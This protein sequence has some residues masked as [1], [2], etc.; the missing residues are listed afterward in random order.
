MSISQRTSDIDLQ[1]KS[2]YW[3]SICN[4]TVTEDEGCLNHHD[5]YD[6]ETEA[7]RE[8][9]ENHLKTIFVTCK[10][11]WNGYLAKHREVKEP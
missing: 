10:A 2:C 1:K 9:A 11:Q 8:M 3:C 7:G 5:T 4:A 6:L